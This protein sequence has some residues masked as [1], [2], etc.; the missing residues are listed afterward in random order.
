M[1]DSLVIPLQWPIKTRRVVVSLTAAN[2]PVLLFPSNQNRTYYIIG[3][4]MVTASLTASPGTVQYTLFQSLYVS[5]GQPQYAGTTPKG[6]LIPP[7]AYLPS[8]F[9]GV[10]QQEIWVWTG[11]EQSTNWILV[12]FEGVNDTNFN[13]S[14]A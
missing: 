11:Y 13:P 10:S 3:N 14:T 7:G 5:F 9:G 4:D 6:I 2:S 8:Q 12:A 1:A